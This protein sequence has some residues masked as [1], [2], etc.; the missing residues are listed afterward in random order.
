MGSRVLARVG[1]GALGID[2]GLGSEVYGLSYGMLDVD[3]IFCRMGS[4]VSDTVFLRVDVL[5]SE[6]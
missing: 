5:G 6:I 4:G 2:C 1:S 3:F